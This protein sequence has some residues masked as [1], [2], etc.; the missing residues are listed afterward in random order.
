MQN[1]DLCSIQS[2]FL[3]GFLFP[4]FILTF[5]NTRQDD[6]ANLQQ[7]PLTNGLPSSILAH[8]YHNFYTNERTS[9]NISGNSELIQRPG[10][11]LLSLKIDAVALSGGFALLV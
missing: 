2:D 4:L 10:M 5:H 3:K 7:H 11:F 8:R 9:D 6:E 1:L